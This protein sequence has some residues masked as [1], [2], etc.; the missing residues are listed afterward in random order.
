MAD[1][2]PKKLAL[3]RIMQILERESDVD[4]P[5]KQEDIARILQRDYGIELE[6]K[7]VGRNLALLEEAGFDI[8]NDRRGSYL[9][10]RMFDDNE[11]RLLIDS[12]LASKHISAKDSKSLIDRLFGGSK[13]SLFSA[14]LEDED[15][16]AEDLDALR[17]MIGKRQ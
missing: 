13:K 8:A 9:C 14:L 1:Q 6:R 15:L 16:S 7:A 12:I 3:I 5:L 17:E 11:L 2:E 4:H 10:E